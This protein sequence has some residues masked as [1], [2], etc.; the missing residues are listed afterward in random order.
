MSVI[1]LTHQG[2]DVEIT[3]FILGFLNFSDLYED[4]IHNNVIKT[5]FVFYIPLYGFTK[6]L[7]SKGSQH[8]VKSL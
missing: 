6:Y 7:H 2:F 3:L 4:D 8:F 5:K 1:Y